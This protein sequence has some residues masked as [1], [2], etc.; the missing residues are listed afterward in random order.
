VTGGLRLPALSDRLRAK[1]ARGASL[2]LGSRNLDPVRSTGSL[3]IRIQAETGV[4]SC[5]ERRSFA[6]S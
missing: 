5:C 1:N 4:A 2:R 3:E 6:N